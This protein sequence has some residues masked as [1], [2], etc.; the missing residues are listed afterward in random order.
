MCRYVVFYLAIYGL[1][2]F[3]EIENNTLSPYNRL[4]LE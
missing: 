3:A 1:P 4:N 2:C